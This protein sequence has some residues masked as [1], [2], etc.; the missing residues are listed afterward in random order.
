MC[1]Q[2]NTIVFEISGVGTNSGIDAQGR[3]TGATTARAPVR[4]CSRDRE[5]GEPRVT[6]SSA[7]QR[8]E[9]SNLQ[10][11]LGHVL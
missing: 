3:K 11:W 6:A 4:H 9:G 8:R 5:Y 1:L 10:C 2:E 7:I